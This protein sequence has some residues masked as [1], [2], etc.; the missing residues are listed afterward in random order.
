[1]TV[2]HW[3]RSSSPREI[4]REVVVIGGGICG[5]SA[6]LHLQRR[7][8]PFAIVERHTVGSGASQRNA[9]F[10]M[11]GA[12]DNYAAAVGEYGRERARLVWRWTEE[13]LAG[14][15]AEGLERVA[16]QRAVP[17]C[18]LALTGEELGQLRASRALLEEDG[19]EVGW[20]EGGEDS[21]WRSKEAGALAGLLNPGD[22]SVN[23]HDLMAMLA[24]E[25]P[26]PVIENQEVCRIGPAAGGRVEV[27]TGDMRLICGGVVVGTTG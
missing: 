11:R 23:P 19:F 15:R 12:A 18:L 13:N 24:A 1:M 5:V 14:L 26:E 27:R 25:L 20:I 7:G 9:G 22:A 6:G 8:V 3:R 10:L 17:S 2:S 16:S 4:E 21:I